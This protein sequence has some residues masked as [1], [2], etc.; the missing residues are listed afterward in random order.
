MR[1][2]KKNKK[3]CYATMLEEIRYGKMSHA[4]LIGDKGYISNEVV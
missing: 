2:D 3:G 4:T 1:L